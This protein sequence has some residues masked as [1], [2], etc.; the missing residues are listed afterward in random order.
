MMASGS[1][2]FLPFRIVMV[3]FIMSSYIA[4]TVAPATNV[5]IVFY[6]LDEVKL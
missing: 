2:I 1:F 6:S 3:M 4:N 5:F